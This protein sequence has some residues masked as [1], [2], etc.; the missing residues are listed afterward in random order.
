[1]KSRIPEYLK[2][3]TE[4]NFNM[5][6][7]IQKLKEQYPK[8]TVVRLKE[9]EQE[10]EMLRGLLGTVQFVDD[11]GQIH[12]EWENG[13]SLALNQDVDRFEVIPQM[14]ILLVEPG[15]K[16][17]AEEIAQDLKT[18]QK[19]VGGYIEVIE[20][21]EDGGIIV[22]NEEAKI[23]GMALNRALYT[24]D[25]QEIIDILAG[26]FFI[27]QA[28]DIHFESLEDDLMRTYRKRFQ[29]PE[30]FISLNGKM[31]AIP[32]ETTDNEENKEAVK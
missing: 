17:R 22:C 31:I 9:M 32:C 21:F 24:E 16:P 20:P 25:G 2:K 14:R 29:N 26:T 6:T 23:N 11:I 15:K 1:M 28:G 13:S 30:V 18:M 12:V 27:C 3:G 19:T 7:R 4:R 5:N 8:G 10:P